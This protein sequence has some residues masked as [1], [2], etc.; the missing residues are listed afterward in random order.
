[1]FHAPHYL[2][3]SRGPSRITINTPG[4]SPAAFPRPAL[5]YLRLAEAHLPAVLEQDPVPEVVDLH[6][7]MLLQRV[8]P[9]LGAVR[10]LGRM[11]IKEY[12]LRFWRV[13]DDAGC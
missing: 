7:V 12:K 1:M 10:V 8:A 2:I 5:D 6:A 13:D 11:P 4:M 9:V 3:S